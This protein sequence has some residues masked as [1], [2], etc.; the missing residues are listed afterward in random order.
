MIF[1]A[2]TN[3]ETLLPKHVIFPAVRQTM[4]QCVTV[5]FPREDKPGNNI[6]YRHVKFLEAG[7][8]ANHETLFASHCF[9][10][11]GKPGNIVC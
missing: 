4:K 7:Q 11:V 1:L 2:E 3:Q 9:L 6:Y 8:T 10:K 5:M